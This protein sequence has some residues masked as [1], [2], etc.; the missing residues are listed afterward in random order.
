MKTV[1]FLL[2]FCFG[3]FAQ[4]ATYNYNLVLVPGFFNS[5]IPAPNRFGNPW[6]QPYFSREIVKAVSTK[7]AKVWV[8]DTLSPLGGIKENGERLIQFLVDHKTQFGDVPVVLLGHSAGGLYAMYASAHTTLPINHIIAFNTPFRGLKFLTELERKGIPIE[9]L[10][11]PFC[12]SNLIQLEETPVQNFIKGL[13]FNR[14][15]RMDV[16]ASY[17]TTSLALWD[18]R[19]LSSPL[20]PFQALMNEPSDGIVTLKS[21]LNPSDLQAK[22]NGLLDIQ[23]HTKPFALE[24]WEAAVDPDLTRLYG[25]LNVGSLSQAQFETYF[26]IMEQSGF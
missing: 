24:H 22:N 1:L 18:Y 15:V 16:F 6:E 13:Q 5:A 25:V 10:A 20:L 12:L 9:E 19:Y 17:Q 3:L 2:A 11:A 26:S 7:V 23:V 14:K 4:A 8:V 21:A